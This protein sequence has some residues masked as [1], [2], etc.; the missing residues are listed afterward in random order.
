MSKIRQIN[1]TYKGVFVCFVRFVLRFAG[2]SRWFLVL[3]YVYVIV[4]ILSWY[5]FSSSFCFV[6]HIPYRRAQHFFLFLP[7][8]FFLLLSYF[9]PS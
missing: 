9:S 6:C 1:Q 4:F 3:L 2:Y 7:V 8:D 5:C